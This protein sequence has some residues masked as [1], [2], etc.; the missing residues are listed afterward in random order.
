MTLAKA[1]ALILTI[2][3]AVTLLYGFTQGN[4]SAE[5]AILTSI[6]WGIVSLIDVYIMFALF[7]G[8]VLFREASH[9]RA[10]LWVVLI[11][12][13]GSFITGLYT[14]LAL[15]SSGGDWHRFWLGHRAEGA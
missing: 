8:W 12:V 3:M 15:M 6:P 10:L 5:G 9:V 1:I 13:L 4:L 14:F 2:I 11:M 7:S